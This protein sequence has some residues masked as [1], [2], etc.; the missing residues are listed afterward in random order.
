[1]IFLGGTCNG[2]T[3]RESLMP[4][5][6][7]LRI[8]YFNPVVDDWNDEAKAKEEEIKSRPDTI[9]LY[10]ITDEMAGFYSLAEAVDAS[11]KCPER[12]IFYFDSDD[13]DYDTKK[14]NSLC[15]IARLISENGGRT[16][17]HFESLPAVCRELLEKAKAPSATK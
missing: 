6:Q 12:T 16:V 5:L 15:E 9:Q 3:W 17:D 13:F 8:P 2:S 7:E 11:N 10:V 4:S 1:M 14:H